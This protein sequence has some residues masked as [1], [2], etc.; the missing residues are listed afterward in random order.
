[1]STAGGS[2]L[3]LGVTNLVENLVLIIG[4]ILVS[5]A[6][7]WMRKNIEAMRTILNDMKMILAQKKQE[8][9][10]ADLNSLLQKMD[11]RIQNM[12]KGA[13]TLEKG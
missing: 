13:D 2:L 1:M 5:F 7:N 10:D 11:Q 3:G 4:G 9:E 6:M 12:E 8:K